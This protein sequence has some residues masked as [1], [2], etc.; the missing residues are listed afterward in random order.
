MLKSHKKDV[1]LQPTFQEIKLSGAQESLMVES[2]VFSRTVNLFTF[3][4]LSYLICVRTSCLLKLVI[5][6]QINQAI[7]KAFEGGNWVL[8]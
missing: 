3:F 4:P 8:K 7:L 5:N 2:D 1:N 6:L